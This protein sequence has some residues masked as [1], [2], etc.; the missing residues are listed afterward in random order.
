MSVLS[1]LTDLSRQIAGATQRAQASIAEMREQI[2]AKRDEVFRVQTSYPPKDEL[3]EMR[4]L[5][6]LETAAAYL[7]ED[8]LS[9]VRSMPFTPRHTMEWRELCATAGSVVEQDFCDKIDR[10]EY[11]AGPSAA[12]RPVEIA[13]LEREL[14]EL[15]AAEEQA[16]DEATA[17][18]VA[19]QHQPEVITRRQ[20]EAAER[21]RHDKWTAAARTRQARVD[22]SVAT[23]VVGS[24]EYLEQFK[25]DRDA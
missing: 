5:E 15:E 14:A 11:V 21:E 1:K 24:S 7:A 23:R 9:F 13:R 20:R 17:A 10:A 22:R 6:I 25:A 19:I 4:R 2:A 18:G 12:E 3:K 16:I 8:P